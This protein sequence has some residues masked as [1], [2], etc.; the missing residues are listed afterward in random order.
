MTGHPRTW[1]GGCIP[2]SYPTMVLLPWLSSM[3]SHGSHR[4]CHPMAS[5]GWDVYPSAKCTQ[6]CRLS[7]W[8][9][10]TWSLH[11][12]SV[13]APADVHGRSCS[14]PF[15]HPREVF[16][17]W[18]WVYIRP[19]SCHGVVSLSLPLGVGLTGGGAGTLVPYLADNHT[20]WNISLWHD[21]EGSVAV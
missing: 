14:F 3:H 20:W 4:V 17:A 1:H 13:D 6:S 12:S 10:I 18:C 21:E 19:P 2:I 7:Y 16:L 8:L 9:H 5:I 15:I 11:P